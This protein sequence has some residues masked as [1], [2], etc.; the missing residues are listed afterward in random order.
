MI[1]IYFSE[2]DKIYYYEG[3][4]VFINKYGIKNIEKL[5]EAEEE[6]VAVKIAEFKTSVQI[7]ATFD[8][9]YLKRIHGFLF[10]ELYEWAGEIRKVRITKGNFT[11]AFVEQIENQAKKLFSELKEEK[12]LQDYEFKLFIKR[13][14]YYMSELNV[15][16]PF[17]EGNG[18]VNRLFFRELAERNG[19]DL[20]FQNVGKEQYLKANIIAA[21]I[22]EY[23]LLEEVLN[24]CV[25]EKE[26]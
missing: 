17:R 10:E 23:S 22:L 2:E 1:K 3:S 25:K 13:L 19:Y 7:S 5:K 4:K 12:Y 15:I 9:E 20:N 8:F 16:H 18:R 14:A 24:L 26:F 21:Q 11:F 6:I